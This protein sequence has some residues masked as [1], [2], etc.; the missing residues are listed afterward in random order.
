MKKI[1]A[2]GLFLFLIVL[3]YWYF[4]YKDSD[5]SISF[6]SPA[7]PTLI[8]RSLQKDVFDGLSVLDQ[9]PNSPMHLTQKVAYRGEERLLNWH[10]FTGLDSVTKVVLKVN[11]PEVPVVSRFRLL[12]KNEPFQKKLLKEVKHFKEDL[13]AASQLYD[14]EYLEKATA[15]AAYCACLS[16]ESTVGEKAFKMMESIDVLSGFVLDHELEMKGKPR[17]DV[18]AWDLEKDFIRFD[19]CFPIQKITNFPD[20]PV[21]FQKQIPAEPALKAIYT[22][23]YMFSHEAWFVLYDQASKKNL[24]VKKEPLEIFLDN[25]EMGGEGKNWKAEIYL[26]LE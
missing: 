2:G 15:P 21:V 17:V 22:G 24:E 16:L 14:V 11:D 25:P 12:I 8:S 20:H 1:F 18:K 19:F 9:T 5:F 10:F 13:E 4:L 6:N 26:P 3:G 7:S 23:N